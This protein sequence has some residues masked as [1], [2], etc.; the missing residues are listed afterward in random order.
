MP[1]LVCRVDS[2]DETRA[3]F[4][5]NRPQPVGRA[6]S[7]DKTQAFFSNRRVESTLRFEMCDPIDKTRYV[8]Q[9]RRVD[10]FQ[11]ELLEH[12]LNVDP[13]LRF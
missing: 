10:A 6:D 1:Q 7:S 8:F 11:K 12:F 2:S 5:T 3:F 4:S 13:T 9:N